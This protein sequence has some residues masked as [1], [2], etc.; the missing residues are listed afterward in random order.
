MGVFCASSQGSPSSS[1][2]ETP[3]FPRLS[4]VG[5]FPCKLHDMLDYAEEN[6]LEHIISWTADGRAFRVNK[7]NELSKILP[8]FF[9]LTKH[10]SFIRQLHLWSYEK[11]REGPNRGAMVHPF[12]IRGRRKILQSMS[13]DSFK[14]K[15]FEKLT[16]VKSDARISSAF[17][18]NKPLRNQSWPSSQSLKISS[19]SNRT[20]GLFESLLSAR[21]GQTR[22]K[23]EITSMAIRHCE[24]TNGTPRTNILNDQRRFQEGEEM[25]FEGRSF[26]FVDYD[27]CHRDIW[28]QMVAD[29]FCVWPTLG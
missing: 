15:S 9:G 1:S 17:G 24:C 6:G 4:S 12:F 27:S 3:H 18:S 11:V 28:S 5:L 16:N 2:I 14:N 25:Y 19:H 21:E 23:S 29:S 7:P 26:Y 22:N 8:L 20:E 10:S 13:R